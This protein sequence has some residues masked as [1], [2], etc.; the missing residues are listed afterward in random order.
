MTTPAVL[1][2]IGLPC[3]N[4]RSAQYDGTPVYAQSVTYAQAIVAAGGVP[5]MIPLNLPRPSLRRLYDLTAGI[6]LA[7]GGDIDPT[8]YGARI[9][10]T[11]GDV[12]PDRD[13]DELEITRWAV[14]D[15]RPLLGICRGI[16]VI[17]VATGGS[18]I[19]D[20]PSEVSDAVLHT[21]PK[22]A[23]PRRP[24][25]AIYH[26]I[27]L[28]P[29]SRLAEIVE[30]GTMTVNS[31]HHQAI[32]TVPSPFEIVGRS[33]DGVVEA[34]EHCDHPFLIGVQWHPELMTGKHES[35]VRIFRA[36]V[37][38]CHGLPPLKRS[39]HAWAAPSA[40][41]QVTQ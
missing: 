13:R 27:S 28:T 11:L 15:R 18:L 8:V 24:D 26:A 5:F 14:A 22:A 1:P 16:Q 7:G 4:D 32:R 35:A 9:H 29:S 40:N 20:I 6:L 23:E 36:F 19:Q 30:A 33:S 3:Q 41:R 31:F 34:I 38:A 21:K 17:A 10:A 25:S 12:Q 37:Q 2:L 39:Q